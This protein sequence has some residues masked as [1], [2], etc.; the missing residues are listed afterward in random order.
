MKFVVLGA[1]AIGAYVGAALDRGGARRHADRARSAPGRDGRT[2][3][4]GALA[5]RRLHRAPQNHRRPRCSRGR[6]RGVRRPQG[7]QPAR[8]RAQARPA[9]RPGSGGD[10]GAERHPLVVPA[11]P[12]ERGSGRGDR[13]VDPR[14]AQRRLRRVL[15]HRDH[16]ARGDQ[17]HRGHQVHDRRA[18]RGYIRTVSSDLG[19]VQGRR[20]QGT[21][22]DQAGRPDL[23][24]A[25]RQRGLQPGDGADQ[26]DA[27]PARHRARDGGPAAGDLRRVRR[28]SPTGS[29]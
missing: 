26:G 21:G 16:R 22:G 15:L 7:L 5:A 23:A 20:A 27:R 2:R 18:G 6:G 3:R 29:G 17:A 25:D 9:A 14:R 13:E 4:P 11:R 24:E 10:L 12:G 1:G 28:R 19:G 8:D